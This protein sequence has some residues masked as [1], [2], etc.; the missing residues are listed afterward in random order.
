MVTKLVC[1]YPM[2]AGIP[3]PCLNGERISGFTS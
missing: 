2:R 1:S 3:D